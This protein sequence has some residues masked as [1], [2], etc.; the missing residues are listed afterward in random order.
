MVD[1]ERFGVL[2]NH[3]AELHFPPCRSEEKNSNDIIHESYHL[4]FYNDAK[5]NDSE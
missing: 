2:E 4:R 5:R 1:G 3:T